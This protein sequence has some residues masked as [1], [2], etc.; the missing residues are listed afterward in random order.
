VIHKD[1]RSTKYQIHSVED[2]RNSYAY[3]SGV[4]SLWLFV[5]MLNSMDTFCPSYII[6]SARPSI[7]ILAFAAIT[8][9]SSDREPVACVTILLFVTMW[10]RLVHRRYSTNILPL[11]NFVPV[12]CLYLLMSKSSVTYNFYKCVLSYILLHENTYVLKDAIDGNP[13][14]L[15]FLPC[16]LHGDVISGSPSPN[17][18]LSFVVNVTY[19]VK[20]YYFHQWHR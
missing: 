17:P 15:Y 11:G 18:Y 19:F 16:I 4:R 1:T 10:M 12:L 14:W 20:L 6:L 5:R 13:W 8:F 2:C 7:F 3:V 9:C